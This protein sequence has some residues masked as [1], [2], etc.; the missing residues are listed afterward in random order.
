MYAHTHTHFFPLYKDMPLAE[1]SKNPILWRSRWLIPLLASP[2]CLQ[3]T[4]K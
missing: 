2:W 1:N 3:M 4:Q